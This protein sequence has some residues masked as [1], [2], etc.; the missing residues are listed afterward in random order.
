MKDKAI[1]ERLIL[2]FR[3]EWPLRAVLEYVTYIIYVLEGFNKWVILL[4]TAV[5]GV[6][7][8]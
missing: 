2:F 1:N 5:L 7:L 4:K 3:E 6:K 8:L